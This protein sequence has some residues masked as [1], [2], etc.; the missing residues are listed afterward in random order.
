MSRVRDMQRSKVYSWEGRTE[1]R[2]GHKLSRAQSVKYVGQMYG[3]H[4]AANIEESVIYTVNLEDYGAKRINV[5]QGLREALPGISLTRSKHI[6]DTVP[7]EV[8]KYSTRGQAEKAREIILALPHEDCKANTGYPH[9][10]SEGAVVTVKPWA[11]AVSFNTR[12]STVS[13]M[14]SR[15]GTAIA[16]TDTEDTPIELWA[17]AHEVAHCVTPNED[18]DKTGGDHGRLF[19]R[20]LIELLIRFKVVDISLAELE[21][22]AKA[23]GVKV[24]PRTH[25]LRTKKRPKSGAR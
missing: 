24:A 20:H 11:P 2:E 21:A 12:R 17:V 15:D 10:P 25:S 19:T 4:T 6:A 3:W 7:S 18:C 8:G 22:S 1:G 14:A 13:G 9:T 16:F 5:I 23:A